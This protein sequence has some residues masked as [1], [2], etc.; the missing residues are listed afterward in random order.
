MLDG[1]RWRRLSRRR[2]IRALAGAAPIEYGRTALVVGVIVGGVFLVIRRGALD[3]VWNRNGVPS[4]ADVIRVLA[5]VMMTIAAAVTLV[6]AIACSRCQR[7]PEWWS[8]ALRPERGNAGARTVDGVPP[9]T[10]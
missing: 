9:G 10:G 2:N 4:R 6:D 5:M 1:V 8:I 3:G 7:R